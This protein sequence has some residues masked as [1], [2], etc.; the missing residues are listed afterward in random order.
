MIIINHNKKWPF[1][2]QFLFLYWASM[3][4]IVCTDWL[5]KPSSFTFLEGDVPFDNCVETLQA[6]T[7]LLENNHL[8]VYTLKF[9][10]VLVDDEHKTTS[11]GMLLMVKK[12][13]ILRNFLTQQWGRSSPQ[14]NNRDNW[15]F[16]FEFS[17]HQ[18]ENFNL[19]H[20]LIIALFL[21]V[22]RRAIIIVP[23]NCPQK[24][25][26]WKILLNL[27]FQLVYWKLRCGFWIVSGVDL[28]AR[29]I[30]CWVKKFCK[31][32]TRFTICSLHWL[33]VWCP[34]VTTISLNFQG[35]FPVVLSDFVADS[36]SKN[37][38]T[39]EMLLCLWISGSC[40]L[41][42]ILPHFNVEGDTQRS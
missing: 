30:H 42:I 34:Y 36:H 37:L 35:D 26:S 24:S 3:N 11:Q 22:L 32:I 10:E 12:A 2:I 7:K 17:V 5:E 13:I 39:L 16:K 28:R 21:I 20:F 40:S 27:L 14:V 9:R 25:C 6:T 4:P 38:P 31:M 33:V 23:R 8:P 29:R 1:C 15:D 19:E 18:A 41:L